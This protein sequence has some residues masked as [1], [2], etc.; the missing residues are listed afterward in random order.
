MTPI[1]PL[2]IILQEEMGRRIRRLR[3]TTVQ[4]RWWRSG[5]GKLGVQIAKKVPLKAITTWV[6]G[7]DGLITRTTTN[8][9]MENSFPNAFYEVKKFVKDRFFR[10]TPRSEYNIVSSTFHSICPSISDS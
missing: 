7:S 5:E 6:R 3:C 8:L 2:N 4:Q 1:G 10:H 9:K